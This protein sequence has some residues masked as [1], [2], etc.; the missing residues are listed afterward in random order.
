MKVHVEGEDEPLE[1]DPDQVEVEDEDPF[2]TQDEVDS[3]VSKRVSRAERSTR[4]ELQEDDDFFREIAQH[5][6]YEFREDGAIKGSTNDDELKELRK[7]KAKLEDRA[8]RAEELEEQI[9]QARNTQLE[10][11]LLKHASDVQDGAEDDILRIASDRM[12]YDEDEETHVLTGDDGIVFD[13]NGE[14]AGAETLLDELRDEK[15]YLFKDT[16]VSGGSDVTPGGDTSGKRTWSESE[17]EEASK[18]THE[19]DQ[20]TFEDWDTAKEE[21]RVK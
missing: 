7:E 16:E 10:N 11:Q 20:E 5:R 14:P 17:W 13:S 4:N 8:Q 15:P 3:I 18:R 19:M 6:G 2:L 21:G 12:T 9:Q 1:V